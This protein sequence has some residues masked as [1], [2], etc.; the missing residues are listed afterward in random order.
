MSLGIICQSCGIEAP[1][2]HVEFHQNIGMLVMRRRRWVKGKLCKQCVHKHFW[3][4]T[5]TT[6]VLGPWGTISLIVAPCFIVNNL[7][8]YVGALGMPP[9]PPNASVPT[10]TAEAMKKLQPHTATIVQ[11]LNNR[12]PLADV[13]RDIAPKARVTPG[14]VVRFVVAMSQA[15]AQRPTHGFPVQPAAPRPVVPLESIPVEGEDSVA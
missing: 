5:L 2:K 1:A 6:L 4:M 13:A 3:R 10:L 12:E 14:Q 7:V 9:V 11:R 8:R 15:N